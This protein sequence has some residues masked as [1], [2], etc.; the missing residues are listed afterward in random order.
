MASRLFDEKGI[1]CICQ[2]STDLSNMIAKTD[3]FNRELENSNFE[4][5]LTCL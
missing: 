2:F 5:S 4:Q 1:C 3:I